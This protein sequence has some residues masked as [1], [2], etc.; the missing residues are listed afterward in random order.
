MRPVIPVVCLACTRWTVFGA[1]LTCEM[2]LTRSGPTT[3]GAYAFLGIAGLSMVLIQT[4][5][6]DLSNEGGMRGLRWIG[7]TGLLAL[8]A[9]WLGKTPWTGLSLG[10]CGY[11]VGLTAILGVAIEALGRRGTTLSAVRNW[12][13]PFR[14]VTLGLL[15]LWLYRPYL[16][17][18][19][20][21]GSD[22]RWYGYAMA[23]ALSQA[24]SGVVPV[25]VGQSEFMF[26]GSINP[27]RLAPYYQHLGIVLDVITIRALQPV[28]IQHLTVL[29]SALWAG[30][31]C[32]LCLDA[33]APARPWLAWAMAAVYVSAPVFAAALY[34]QEMYMTFVAVAWLPVV[35][36]GNL[37][38]V[39]R[40]DFLGW[41][42][43]AASLSLVWMGHAP[44]GA[45]A[46]LATLGMQ[47]LRLLS[48]DWNWRS[49]VR[50][51]GGLLLFFGL[52]GFYFYSIIEFSQDSRTGASS[53]L[54]HGLIMAVGVGG[55]V[56]LMVTGRSR[57]FVL[58]TA[59]VTLLWVLFPPYARWFS[60]TLG[61]A[62]V[63][64]GAA[65][66]WP[67]LRMRERAPEWSCV[68]L[69]AGG[70]AVLP[71][72]VPAESL[73]ALG[74]VV[75]LF[76]ASLAPI[77]GSSRA[78]SELQIGYGLDLALIGG[79]VVMFVRPQ[80]EVRLLG[81]L[82]FALLGMALPIPGVTRFLLEVVPDTLY[83]ISSTTLW[84]R[85]I[86]LL[87]AVAVFLGHAAI[88]EFGPARGWGRVA[89]A[90]TVGS[91]LGWSL[92]EADKFVRKRPLINTP[93]EVRAFYRPETVR[94]FSYVLR[95]VQ[96]SSYMINGVVDYHLESRLLSGVEP[97]EELDDRLGWD[98]AKEIKFA[99]RVDENAPNWLHLEPALT[100]GPGEHLALKFDF[101]PRTYSGTLVARGLG[102]FYRE[103][104]LPAS[105]F[106]PKSFGVGPG[107]TK[108]LAFWNTGTLPQPVELTF[109]QDELA[110]DAQPFGDF[111]RVRI[112][113]YAP[114]T[115][116]IRTISLVPYRAE[117]VVENG[118]FLETPR[119]FIPGYTATVN[120]RP[121]STRAS[122]NHLVMVPLD[123][124]P[125]RVEVRYT[126][127]VRL[128]LAFLMSAVLWGALV[129]AVTRRS[130]AGLLRRCR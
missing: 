117:T 113:P 98:R 17:P 116:P 60:A 105:G 42:F 13:E 118:G 130:P 52:T 32:Y 38:V 95:N 115:L 6:L 90:L 56:R 59:A 76:P 33:L 24:R 72:G 69:L 39:A 82:A 67:V 91:M 25:L 21:G 20:F 54:F 44:I 75:R 45:W 108:T 119:L 121:V 63:L 64:V 102:G 73:P 61:V 99:T 123:S 19:F 10:Q 55:L 127:T 87:A 80:W 78:L 35:F 27:I 28:A 31:G 30:L 93:D 128:R 41:A 65:G 129:V 49:W 9:G 26:D 101:L 57:W 37:R 85:Y 23:D 15:A 1:V 58:S 70:L 96:M 120:G 86:P 66:R 8:V 104:S 2:A 89:F 12:T 81:L 50:A 40:E 88:A 74:W 79:L 22:A 36:Y 3:A 5:M 77:H 126:G 43:L 29:T 112:L 111:A 14:L 106:F 109:L 53:D 46:T 11:L 83:D 84:P 4:W 125:N 16:T 71:F 92:H 18:D 114:E 100:L 7:G 110:K 107:R 62:A 68:A 97:T 48:R 122:P 47:G 51:G 34:L 103:Y 124:G 94:Q